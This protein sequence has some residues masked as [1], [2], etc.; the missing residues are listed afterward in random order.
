[1][2][3][4]WKFLEFFELL[5]YI[6]TIV[7][8]PLAIWIFKREE[9]K[10]RQAEQEEI[11]DKLM[12]HYDH[13]LARLFEHPDIDQHNTPLE[14][15]ELRRQQKILYEMLATCSSGPL[16]CFTAKKSS[17]TGVCGTHGKITSRTGSRARIS[18]KC[19]PI[20]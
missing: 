18:L 14:D 13:I 10:E 4:D 1:M 12:D 11:Y 17:P 19:C 20:S 8:I 5:S 16:F 2:M 9:L 6:A 15:A 7:G 3:V